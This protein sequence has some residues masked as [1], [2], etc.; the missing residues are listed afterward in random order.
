ML[1]LSAIPIEF[2][3]FA[4]VLAGVAVWHTRALTIALI[5]LAAALAYKLLIAG[6]AGGPGF[7]GLAI[8]LSHEWVILVNLMLL[9]VG[10][11]LLAHHFEES[12]LPHA[13]PRVLPSSWLGGLVLLALVFCLSIFLDNIAGA[14]IGGVVAKHVYRGRVG[15]GF[16]ASIVAAANAG[17]AGSVLGDTTT[18]MMWLSGISPLTVAPAFIGAA[19][20]FA[21]FGVFGAL[22]QHRYAPVERHDDIGPSIDWGRIF[23]VAFSLACVV[24]ANIASNMVYPELEEVAPVLGIALWVGLLIALPVRRPNWHGVPSAAKGALFLVALVALASL[25][26]VEQLPP[27]ST[28][29]I[30]ALGWL[31]A[32]FDNIP[33]TA[34]ALEQG[35]YDWP[36]LAYAVGFGGSMVWFGSSA[37]VALTALFPQGRSVAAWLRHG[38]HIPLAYAAGFALMNVVRQ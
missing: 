11:A 2:Y 1:I 3:M 22:S 5:G 36:L 14:I 13:L 37:G 16:L 15:V 33:L 38:W 35:G 34:L 9:L 4:T 32:V 21:V 12:Q 28:W 20:A 10:F 27:P 17:G 23:A 30:F 8:H 29:T 19:G 25:M 24:A 31:S 18:T 26:P 6:F 7:T